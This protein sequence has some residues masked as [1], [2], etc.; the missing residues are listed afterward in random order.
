MQAHIKFTAIEREIIALIKANPSLT[1]GQLEELLFFAPGSIR[2][3][4]VKIYK[5]IGI[6]TQRGINARPKL[7]EWIKENM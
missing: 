5:K 3:N 2:N 4:F 6:E 7:N 1:N